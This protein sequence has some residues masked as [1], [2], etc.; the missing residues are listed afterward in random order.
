MASTNKTTNYELSQFL[1]TDK[2]AWLS[3]Y[4]SD[5][6]KIDAQMKANADAATAAGSTASSATTAIGTLTDLTTTNKTS[7]VAAINE[8]DSNADTAQNTANAAS[9][10]A[11]TNATAI[12]DLNAYLNINNFT[13]PTVTYTNFTT[14]GTSTNLSCASNNT[15]SLGKIYG[16]I[17]GTSNANSFT[18]TFPTPLRPNTALTLNGIC[19]I[20]YSG[21]NNAW[22]PIP[23]SITIGTDGVATITETDTLANRYY[24][25]FLDACVIFA[26]SFG[27]TQIEN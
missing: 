2:P 1:G 12:S 22:T 18:I 17:R 27:D 8:V 26:K 11:S 24:R 14:T 6:S 3:D 19:T 5:M 9:T 10:L 21:D 7:T 13:S 25:I 23:K 16:Q 4:N 15:G 20:F